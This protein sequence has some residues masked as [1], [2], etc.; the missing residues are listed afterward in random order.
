MSSTRSEDG[1]D[2]RDSGSWTTETLPFAVRRELLERE[3]K[4]LGFRKTAT[5]GQGGAP[6]GGAAQPQRPPRHPQADPDRGGHGD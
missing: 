6:Q 1:P 4:K 5:Q 2:S 3:L